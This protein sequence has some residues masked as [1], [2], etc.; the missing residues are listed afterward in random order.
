M[1]TGAVKI[2]IGIGQRQMLMF[3]GCRGVCVSTLGR[4]PAFSGPGFWW[5]PLHFF[6]LVP[7]GGTSRL[8]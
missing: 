4:P 3:K 7:D 1:A 2:Y 8:P 6:A 5:R